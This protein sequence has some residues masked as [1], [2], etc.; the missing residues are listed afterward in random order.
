MVHPRQL[1][2]SR[3]PN[4]GNHVHLY[5]IH[6]MNIIAVPMYHPHICAMLKSPIARKTLTNLKSP[7]YSLPEESPYDTQAII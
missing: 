6:C 7:S 1:H 5:D 4:L 2:S 3:R